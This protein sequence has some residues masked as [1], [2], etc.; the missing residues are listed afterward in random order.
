M[1]GLYINFFCDSNIFTLLESAGQNIT[2]STATSNT[3]FAWF[4]SATHPYTSALSSPSPQ[5][6]KRVLPQL[7]LTYLAF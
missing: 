3:I 2:I 5:V 1:V 6:N 7:V 4:L